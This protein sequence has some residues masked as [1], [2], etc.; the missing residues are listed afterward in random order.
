MALKD[1]LKKVKMPARVEA[2]D[3]MLEMDF[4][5]EE[6]EESDMEGA[7]PASAEGP[8]LSSLSDN[9]LLAEVKA[10]G[11]SLGSEGTEDESEGT[12]GEDEVEFELEAEEEEE[13]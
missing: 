11:L 1:A 6:S 13:A 10:R 5:S 8:D 12:E 7:E 4:P 2:E 9:E 3:E